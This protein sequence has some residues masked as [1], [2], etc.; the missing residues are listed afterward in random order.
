MRHRHSARALTLWI[1]L[2]WSWGC[3]SYQRTAPS[4]LLPG[5]QKVS[6][7]LRQPRAMAGQNGSAGNVTVTGVYGPLERVSGDTLFVRVDGGFD[8]RRRPVRLAKAEAPLAIAVADTEQIN[9]YRFN[10]RLSI[11]AAVGGLAMAW[12]LIM[13]TSCVMCGFGDGGPSY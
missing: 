7:I 12:A 1:I 5:T 4:A 9:A 2:A 3:S 11:V 13:A 8:E 10:T 6:V